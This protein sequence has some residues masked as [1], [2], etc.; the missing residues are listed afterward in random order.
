M[1][2]LKKHLK[3]WA[4]ATEGWSLPQ[5]RG[6][7]DISQIAQSE[8]A[9]ENYQ[10]AT[11]YK[12]RWIKEDGLEQKLIVTF[13][14][15]YQ[16]YQRCIRSRQIERACKLLESN[17][18][19]L[20]KHRQTDCKRFISR[21]NVTTEG[22]I[23][24]NEFY[25]IDQEIIANEEAYD[26][27]YAVCTNLEEDAPAITKINHKRWEIEECF[28][29]LKSDFRA[30]PVYL[31]RDDRIKAHFT[32]CFLALT[33]YRYLEKRVK[34]NFTSTEIISQLRTMN[35]YCVPGEGYVP[36]YTRTDFTDALH[37]TF[38]FRT[39]YEIV[40]TKQMKKILSLQKKQ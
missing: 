22:E 19:S 1:R 9:K 21:T 29:L 33:I 5:V 38:G 18:S 39:D 17:P 7:F 23:A 11:F 20:K 26:G 10:N 13:S 14:F 36:T 2:K 30:R 28:R 27:F 31:S 34:E 15:K 37:E 8:E 35:F 6:A 16:N 12:E 3:Q 32:T 40:G 25:T 24:K 4:L